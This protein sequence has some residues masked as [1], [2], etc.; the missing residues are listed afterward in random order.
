MIN[1]H[2]ASQAYKKAY[3]NTKSG[4]D[5]HAARLM[6]N[7]S[8]KQAIS[9]KMVEL[10]EK[11]EITKES[12]CKKLDEAHAIAKKQANPSGMVAA[13]REQN[14][15]TGLHVQTILTDTEQTKA[16]TA[17]EQAELEAYAAWKLRHDLRLRPSEAG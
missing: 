16:L 17:T 6:G 14:A 12:Q 5:A 3:P 11:V 13:V 15:I 4:W 7:D 9:D 1:G 8:I 10:A 2:N